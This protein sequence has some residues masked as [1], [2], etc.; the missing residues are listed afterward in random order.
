M[1]TILLWVAVAFSARIVLGEA[2]GLPLLLPLTLMG[3]SFCL[4]SG[5]V[6]APRGRLR[7][8][9][10]FTLFGFPPIMSRIL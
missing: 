1:N 9:L 3:G 7:W 8:G 2:Y 6:A 4:L 10:G 5:L